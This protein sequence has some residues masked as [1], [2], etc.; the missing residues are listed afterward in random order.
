MKLTKSYSDF[1][2]NQIVTGPGISSMFQAKIFEKSSNCVCCEQDA[3]LE[4]DIKECAKWEFVRDEYF[5]TDWKNCYIRNLLLNYRSNIGCWKIIM[6]Y[7]NKAM[8]LLH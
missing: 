5:K 2:V 3:D 4:H 7:F 6:G 1:Y 8:D